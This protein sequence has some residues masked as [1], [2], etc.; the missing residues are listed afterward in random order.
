MMIVVSLTLPVA[1]DVG[2]QTFRIFARSEVGS[3]FPLALLIILKRRKA[4]IAVA[5]RIAAISAIKTGWV[6]P[7]LEARVATIIAGQTPPPTFLHTAYVAL[8]AAKFLA[9][10]FLFLMYEIIPRRRPVQPGC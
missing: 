5:T 2:R 10:A 9:L 7:A 4:S 6:L 1:F 8:E 3:A